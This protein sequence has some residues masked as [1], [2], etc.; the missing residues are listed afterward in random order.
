[1]STSAIAQELRERRAALL[2]ELPAPGAGLN[3]CARYA[4]AVDGAFQRMTHDA[5]EAADGAQVLAVVATGGYGRRELCPWSDVD[6]TVLPAFEGAP[7]LDACI[8]RLFNATHEVFG[9]LGID[10]GWTYR[11]V[12]DAA[13]LDAEVRSALFDA[14]L[15]AGARGP[16][17]ELL[18]EVWHTLPVGE[19][20]IAKIAEREAAFRRYHDTPRVVEPH[21]KEGAGGLRCFHCAEWLGMAMGERPARHSAAYQRVLAMRNQLHAVANRR[22]DHLT[23]TKQAEIA[24]ATGQDLFAMMARLTEAMQELHEV[25]LA[26]REKLR[27]ARYPLADGVQAVRGEIRLNGPAT[28]SATALGIAHGT[29]LGLNVPAGA[30]LGFKPAVD[31]GEAMAALEAGEPAIRNLDR[32]GVLDALLPELASLRNS[33]PEDGH[34]AYTVFEHTL[35]ALRNLGAARSDNGFLGKLYASLGDTAPL[36]LATLLHDTGKAD[37]ARDHAEAGAAI[38]EAVCRRWRLQEPVREAVAWLVREHLTMARFIRM[39]DVAHPDTA[40]EFAAIAGDRERLAMLTLLTWADVSAVS[41]DAWTPA[42]D[43]FLRELFERAGAVLESGDHA[44]PD[45]E[46]YRRRVVRDLRAGPED[47]AALAAFA[48]GLP[49]HYLLGTPPELVRQHFAYARRALAGSP[50]I[51]AFE[52][53][54]LGATDLTVCAPDRPGLLS[55]ILGTLY[56]MDLSLIGFRVC[57]AELERP[58]ALDTFTTTYGGRPLPPATCDA[59]AAALESVL[60]GEVAME[61]LMRR[62]GKDPDRRQE[63][64]RWTYHPGSPG[65]LEV[66]APRGRG[67][68]YRLSRLIAGKGWY[69]LGARLGQWAGQGAAAFYLL[70]PG[71]TELTAEEVHAAL[72]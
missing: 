26:A 36:I 5:L 16:L 2:R 70:G 40:R 22:Q 68:A 71:G 62:R 34:H 38:A 35:R 6:V 53:P 47:E 67:M 18:N 66:R 31:P 39:R 60:R 48:A 56:A 29:R 8:R 12:G 1:M 33:H 41:P 13:G 63:I 24:E 7:G 19:F 10:V 14:R 4:D 3:W 51:E 55:R 58:I 43:G 59:A 20:L 37:P 32:S 42:Q 61:D 54:E 44:A 52:R 64:L 46:T 21:L 23:R 25:Y 65:I 27:E 9:S 11:L 45:P 30:A 15:V 17:D 72:D 50:T 49:A 69:V 57:T 28:L